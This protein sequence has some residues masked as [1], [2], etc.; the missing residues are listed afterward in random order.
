MVDVS[1][2]YSWLRLGILILLPTLTAD[3]CWRSRL[4]IW[5]LKNKEFHW[6]FL[7]HV[8]H[9]YIYVSEILWNH[10]PSDNSGI[11]RLSNRCNLNQ[12]VPDENMGYCI[13]PLPFN[14]HLFQW[15]MLPDFCQTGSKCRSHFCCRATHDHT[16]LEFS[17]FDCGWRP[18]CNNTFRSTLKT[19][20]LGYNLSL[21]E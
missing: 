3:K 15:R 11:C 13:P 5:I 14:T 12:S 6:K 8:V 9:G 18:G 1:F 2:P 21:I 7:E 20:L 16:V 19:G 10:Y 4:H 17:E